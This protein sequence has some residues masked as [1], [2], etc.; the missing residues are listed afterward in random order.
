MNNIVNQLQTIIAVFNANLPFML[1]FIGI[2]WAI[3]F[4]NVLL[5]YRLNFLGLFPRS[6]FGLLGI[7]FM[8]FLHGS[9]NHLI[10]NSIPLFVLGSF[11]LLAGHHQF[12]YVSGI[13]VILSGGLVW[14]FGRRAIHI[15][16]SGLVT[17]YFSYLIIQ[18]YYHPSVLAVIIAITSVYYFGGLL[19]G[20]FP[21]QLKTSWEGH[22][23]GFIAGIIAVFLT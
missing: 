16:A 20:L 11:L 5:R 9:F 6:V 4:V 2:L 21:G 7:I 3:Q 17:G 15:G 18:A 13:I 10:L 8:P 12:F 19:L 14:L 23:F 1:G 22:L